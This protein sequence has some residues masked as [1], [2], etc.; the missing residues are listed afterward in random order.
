MVT[1]SVKVIIVVVVV[2][3]VVV[4]GVRVVVLLLLLLLVVV[5]NDVIG[6]DNDGRPAGTDGIVQRLRI[7]PLLLLL[8]LLLMLLLFDDGGRSLRVFPQPLHRQRLLAIGAG[9]RGR[10][11][12]VRAGSA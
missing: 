9:R 6:T 4:V 7:R 1:V 5:V 2:V 11:H 12:G 10:S 3:V 8:L